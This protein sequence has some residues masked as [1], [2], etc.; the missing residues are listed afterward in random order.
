MWILIRKACLDTTLLD[1]NAK[2]IWN[3]VIA[4]IFFCGNSR[5][6]ILQTKQFKQFDVQTICRT[7]KLYDILMFLMLTKYS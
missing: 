4:T 5:K 3:A 2:Q 1:R 7:L 6:L